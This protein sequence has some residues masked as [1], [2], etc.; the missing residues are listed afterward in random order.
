VHLHRP[1]QYLALFA[2]IVGAYRVYE[3]IVERIN[4][5]ERKYRINNIGEEAY[6]PVAQT[7]LHFA[8]WRFLP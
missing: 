8:F 6:D 2:E 3:N 7:H 4:T 1:E 5:D